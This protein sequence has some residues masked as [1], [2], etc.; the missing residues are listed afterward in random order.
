M[1]YYHIIHPYFGNN[2]WYARLDVL[3]RLAIDDNLPDSERIPCLIDTLDRELDTLEGLLD[4]VKVAREA[5]HHSLTAD[6][7][8][9]LN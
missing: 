9:S 1:R 6:S 7:G 4:S 2:T 8:T 5:G 3:G